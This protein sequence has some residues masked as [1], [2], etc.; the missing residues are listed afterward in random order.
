MQCSAKPKNLEFESPS[1]LLI[2]CE[3]DYI[4]GCPPF[5]N[6][7]FRVVNDRKIYKDNAYID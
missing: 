2:I 3:A 6:I 5:L 1:L 7:N 4:L